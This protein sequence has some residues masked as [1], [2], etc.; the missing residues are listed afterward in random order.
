MRRVYSI[1]ICVILLLVSGCSSKTDRKIKDLSSSSS[2]VRFNA[3]A[4]LSFLS[5]DPETVEKIIGLLNSDNERLVFISAQILGNRKDPAA[6]VPLGKLTAHPNQDIRDRAVQSLGMINTEQTAAYVMNALED[7]SDVVRKTAVKMI[8]VMEYSDGVEDIINSLND[9]SAGVRAEAVHTLY[10][11]RENPDA[12]IVA[13]YF[14]TPLND[15]KPLVRYVAVQALDYAYPD[16]AKAARLLMKALDDKSKP[17][18]EE[19]VNSLGK[20]GYEKAIPRFKK[21]HDL[22]QYDVQIAISEAIKSMTGEDFPAFR[23]H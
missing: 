5:D 16:S 20:I 21:M 10:K 4:Y 14:E 11:F 15:E 18:R 1:A 3:A 2:G 8:G 22:E 19:A 17:V 12:G 6:V 7:S 9:P 13:G 23:G